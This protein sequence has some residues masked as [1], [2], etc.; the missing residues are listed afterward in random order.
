MAG[1]VVIAE[2][3]IGFIHK[4]TFDWLSSAGGAADGTTTGFYTGVLIRY[5]EIPDAAGTQPSSLYDVTVLD[6]DS[7]D[8]LNGL[9]ANMSNTLSSQVMADGIVVTLGVVANA[10]LTLSVTNAG[11]AKGGTTILYLRAA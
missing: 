11:N 3:K 10:Q 4:I 9:G 1:T 7:I 6:D 8:L 2:E 5:V